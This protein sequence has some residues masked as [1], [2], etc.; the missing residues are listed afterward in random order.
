MKLNCMKKLFLSIASVIILSFQLP[1]NASWQSK[2][3]SI[4]KSGKV[5]YNPDERGNTIPDFSRV[6]YYGGDKEIPEVPIV[7]SID[8]NATGNSEDVIQ[9]AIDE[10]SKMSVGKNGFRGTLLLKKGTYRI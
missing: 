4:A 10:I 1:H 5:H 9:S 6:G 8:P 2:F 3:V 7:K